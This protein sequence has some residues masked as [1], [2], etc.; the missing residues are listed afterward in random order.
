[1]QLTFCRKFYMEPSYL[2]THPVY[3]PLS[4]SLSIHGMPITVRCGGGEPVFLSS[5]ILLTNIDLIYA[6]G[7]NLLLSLFKL[8]FELC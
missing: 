4:P 6:V 7:Y 3:A 1:M 5:L 8:I 2:F